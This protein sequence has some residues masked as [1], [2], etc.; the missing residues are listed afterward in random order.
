MMTHAAKRTSP[1][2]AETPAEKLYRLEYSVEAAKQ[3]IQSSTDSHAVTAAQKFI[4][5]VQETEP[6]LK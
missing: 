3:V 6:H 2:R 5:R 4:A 1:C